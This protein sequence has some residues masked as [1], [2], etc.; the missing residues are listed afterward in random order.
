MRKS[1]SELRKHLLLTCIASLP[2][3]L[4]SASAHAQDTVQLGVIIL[5]GEQETYFEQSNDTALKTTTDDGETPFVVSTSNESFIEDIRASHL[6]DVFRYTTG[7]NQSALTADGFVIR[8]FDIDLNNIKVDGLSGLTTRFGSPSTANIERVEVLKGPASV[9]YGNMETG[10]MVNIVTKTPTREATASITTEAETFASDVSGFGDDNGIGTTL[11]FSGPVGNRDDLFYRFIATGNSIDSFREGVNHEEA[12]LYGTVLWDIDDASSLTLGFEAGQQTGDADYGLV[13][14]DNDIDLVAPIDTVYQDDG[15]FDNDEG[16]AL[17]AQYE[18]DLSNGGTLNLNWRSTWH[19]DERELFENNT[20]NDDTETLTRRYRNQNNTRDWHSFDA[21]TT[22]LAQT[23]SVEHALTFGLAGEYRLT[24][25]N[26]LGFGGNADVDVDVF[27]PDTTGTTVTEVAGNRRETEYYSIGLYAQDKIKLNDALTVV[28]S[29]RVNNTTIDFTCLSGSCVDDNSTNT[30]DTVGSLGMVY[31]I[32]PSWTAFAS[33]SQSFDPYTAERVD[34]NGDAL[35]AEKSQQ[36]EAGLRYQLRDQLN[37]SMSAYQIV[38]DNV[39]ESLGGGIYETVGE[40]ESKGG[41]LD[42][43]WQPS[44]NWQF[45]A[46]YAYNES[47]ATE[48]EDAGLTPANAPEN[49]FSFFTRYNVPQPVLGGD[50]GFSFGVNYRDEVKTSISDSS[51]VTLP[52]YVVAD[53]GVY[54]DK[55]DWSTS[56]GVSNVL[57]ET[58]Y[59]GGSGDTRL[60][61]GDPRKISV[62]LTRNF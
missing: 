54:F 6:E 37:A 15:D 29:L 35:D 13:A 21:Y 42:L 39:S 18:R 59:F 49:T 57:D 16:Y 14:I 44:P 46:G 9:L 53:L 50:L 40:V 43:Q 12:Y 7:V 34:V 11:D 61:A 10:G 23:G 62:S 58:Y 20:V 25:F 2:V 24:D 41:E 17:T 55:N 38:K 31:Q 52:S 26:R 19:E 22:Q 27:D 5:H 45:K 32:N 56:L 4:F 3:A 60:Y 51:S 30:Q 1:S 48:G 33:V 8:G 47:E 36:L 28:G